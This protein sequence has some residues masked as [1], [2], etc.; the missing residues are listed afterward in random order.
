MGSRNGQPETAP[1]SGALVGEKV[2]LLESRPH[3]IP[4]ASLQAAERLGD[5]VVADAEERQ[6]A[7]QSLND[8]GATASERVNCRADMQDLRVQLANVGD[9]AGASGVAQVHVEAGSKVRP[10]ANATVRP[11]CDRLGQ[12]LFRAD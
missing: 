11:E 7:F 10:A 2:E 6:G 1:G 9:V 3:A 8:A 4:L 5:E 12:H